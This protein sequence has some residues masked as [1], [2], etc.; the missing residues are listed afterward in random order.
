MANV[1]MKWFQVLAL[2]SGLWV[3]AGAWAD[4]AAENIAVQQDVQQETTADTVDTEEAYAEE[5]EVVPTQRPGYL[6]V[7]G[8]AILVRPITLFGTFVGAIIWVVTSPITA[9]TGTI[10]EAGQ[11]L[12]LEPA[13]TTFYRCLG[14]TEVGWRKL[15]KENVE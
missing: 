6:A 14:C 15:P 3:A 4:E 1:V 5:E 11:T 7:I 9:I 13:A 12:V 2:A 8:D 10:G